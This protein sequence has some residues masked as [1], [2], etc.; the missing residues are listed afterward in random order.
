MSQ[1]DRSI[2]MV[3]QFPSSIEVNRGMKGDVGWSIKIRG[4]DG[5]EFALVDRAA[6]IDAALARRFGKANPTLEAQLGASIEQ[7]KAS[8]GNRTTRSTAPTSSAQAV[9]DRLG[10]AI[11]AARTAQENY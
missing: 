5:E 1:E 11:E 7:V 9:S 6:D 10:K 8:K 4:G 3:E 2:E